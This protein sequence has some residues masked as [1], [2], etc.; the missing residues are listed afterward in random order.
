MRGIVFPLVSH[1]KD[2]TYSC[3]SCAV[4]GRGRSMKGGARFRAPLS[5]FPVRDCVRSCLG[6][7]L[8]PPRK[9]MAVL[10]RSRLRLPGQN[11]R[12]YPAAFSLAADRKCLS[13]RPGKTFG[14]ESPGRRR[15]PSQPVAQ[16]L[17][18]YDA[19]EGRVRLHEDGEVKPSVSPRGPQGGRLLE[20]VTLDHDARSL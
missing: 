20:A 11:R 18:A 6:Y 10:E 8:R 13:C 7:I 12:A 1:N 15:P 9:K 5:A 2:R 19:A 17:H 3:W 4:F 14:K 16:R